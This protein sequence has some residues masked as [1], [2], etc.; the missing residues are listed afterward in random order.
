MQVSVAMRSVGVAV[1]I[2]LSASYAQAE[3]RAFSLDGANVQKRANNVLALLGYSVVPDLA[4]SSLSIEDAPTGNPSIRMSQLAGGFTVSRSMPLY[5]EG[6]IAA[7]RYDPKFTASNGEEQ[8]V[9]PVKWVSLAFTSGIGWDFPLAGD[10]KLRPMLNFSLG[11]V[12]S[13]LK[14]ARELIDQL[15]DAALDF[16]DDGRL[17]AYGLG[18][19]LMLDYERYRPEDEVDVELRYTAIRLKSYGSTAASVQGQADAI[20]ASL[21]SRY[22]APAGWTALDRPV[23]YVLE[24]AFTSYLG[25][26]AGILGFDHLNSVGAGLELDSSAHEIFITRTRLLIRYMFGKDVSGFS[27]GLAV[28]F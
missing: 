1:L 20:T 17:D 14:V 3:Q 12:T 13:D 10:L 11:R 7:S 21:W 2:G 18:G 28:S 25:D 5:L 23:R 8:R 9:V 22:R 6:G 24:Y 19:S 16:L 15:D 27:V 4:S 26:Q